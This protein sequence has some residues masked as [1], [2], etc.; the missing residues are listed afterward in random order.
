[1]AMCTHWIHIT[2]STNARL[3]FYCCYLHNMVL[4]Q[5]KSFL[6]SNRPLRGGTHTSAKDRGDFKWRAAWKEWALTYAQINAQLSKL[7]TPETN[8]EWEFSVAYE[9]WCQ[10][11]WSEHN[12]RQQFALGTI[13]PAPGKMVLL[14]LCKQ[15]G[16]GLG[17]HFNSLTSLYSASASSG[18]QIADDMVG[19]LGT[20][21]EDPLS[22]RKCSSMGSW[23]VGYKVSKGSFSVNQPLFL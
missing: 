20:F 14:L 6:E 3:G 23:E 19:F 12:K 21:P 9:F 22:C 18:P 16:G 10:V 4:R 17:L 15:K 7:Q 1:M 8:T 5:K 2:N 13:P 11:T